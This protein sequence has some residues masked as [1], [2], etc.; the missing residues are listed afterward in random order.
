VEH[1]NQLTAFA[2]RHAIAP[3]LAHALFDEL[4]ATIG[5]E[6]HYIF[7]HQRS[8]GAG[9]ASSG[10]ARTILA[11]PSPDAALAFAQRNRLIASDAS[12]RLRRLTLLQLVSALLSQPSI[13]AL[14][15]VAQDADDRLVAG[16][17]PPGVL[18]ERHVIVARYGLV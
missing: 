2:D 15:F 14:L 8:T 9:A 16:Q 5:A 10:R 18:I 17:L 6:A 7:W 13:A 11:F 3:A 1:D 4:L 12:A